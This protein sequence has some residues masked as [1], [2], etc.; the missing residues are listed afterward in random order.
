MQPVLRSPLASDLTLDYIAARIGIEHGWSHLYS[1]TLQRQLFEQ[2]RPGVVFN[3]GQWFI[4]PPPLA[5]L[6]LPLSALGP[7]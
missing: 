3:D 6:A 4:S 5:W 1:L 7:A 2:V